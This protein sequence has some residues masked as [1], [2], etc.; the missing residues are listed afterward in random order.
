LIRNYASV[1]E[2]IIE[3]TLVTRNLYKLIELIDDSD[4]CMEM[5]IMEM[6]KIVDLVVFD[7][8]AGKRG[9]IKISI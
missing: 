3:Q 9:I 1:K 4:Y 8:A 2:K 6:Q 5:L 7:K